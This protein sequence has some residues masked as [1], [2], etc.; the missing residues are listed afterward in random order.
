MSDSWGSGIGDSQGGCNSW[1]CMNSGGGVGD[2]RGG[3][4]V[5]HCRSGSL[6]SHCRG[7][8]DG[9]GSVV[10]QGG[11]SR[12]G[13]S[14]VADSDV[15]LPDAREW[16]VDG[17]GVGGHLSEVSVAPEDVGLLGGD[18]GGGDCS[19]G[20]VSVGGGGSVTHSGGPDVT[21]VGGSHEGG[22]NQYLRLENIR[23]DADT[24]QRAVSMY[25]G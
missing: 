3:S 18:G 16:S 7:G 22:E 2:G 21:G 25:C 24:I 12:V 19:G 6:V 4:L 1:S 17:L 14:V 20:C 9:G 10:S 13:Q 8:S 11:G 23:K 15:G 5:S